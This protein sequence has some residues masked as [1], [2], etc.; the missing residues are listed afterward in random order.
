VERTIFLSEE[1][2]RHQSEEKIRLK[3]QKIYRQKAEDKKE[4]IRLEKLEKLNKLNQQLSK[5]LGKT[6]WAFDLMFQLI[7]SRYEIL[8]NKLLGSKDPNSKDLFF[9][10]FIEIYELTQDVN[11]VEQ[12]LNILNVDKKLEILTNRFDFYSTIPGL[13]ISKDICTNYINERLT[14][15]L[16]IDVILFDHL[17]DNID[18]VNDLKEVEANLYKGD[19][20][21]V[22][23]NIISYK[24]SLMLGMFNCVKSLNRALVISRYK[25]N[26]PSNTELYTIISNLRKQF[27][28]I[29]DMGNKLYPIYK[30][31]YSNTFGELLDFTDL[32]ILTQVMDKQDN[33]FSDYLEKKYIPIKDKISYLIENVNNDIRTKDISFSI[34][35]SN[36]SNFIKDIQWDSFYSKI[37]Q[38][39]TEASFHMLY[40]F[41]IYNLIDIL[42]PKL[43]IENYS[44]YIEIIQ[45][46]KD[47]KRERELLKEKQ[48]FLN[49]DFTLENAVELDRFN[50]NNIKTGYEFE[51]YLRNVFEKLG[52]EAQVTKASGDQGADLIIQK[53]G[54]I[55]VVQAKYYTGSVGNKAVQEITG[56]I[57]FYNA[58]KG[59]VVTNSYYTKSAIILAKAN[60]IVLIDGDG[61][62]NLKETIFKALNS[63]IYPIKSVENTVGA[64][65]E[66]IISKMTEEERL[67][68]LES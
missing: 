1:R 41:I 65:S 64:L 19:E 14:D 7:Y 61:L 60:N 49:G 43:L 67:D 21:G 48:R 59:M 37:N 5:E 22:K 23:W 34:L 20:T 3:D 58:H 18:W 40:S 4:K 63:N 36:F 51:H 6:Y 2:K 45:L 52:F 10:I 11:S 17:T 46:Y 32:L 38:P 26:L 39:G 57:N 25:N 33:P 27:P 12:F 15:K 42:P 50:F 35:I 31:F 55:T 16:T 66:D 30:E 24:V 13:D 54:E 68:Y 47:T 44:R 29:T 56:A 8:S 53:Q 28:N 62:S 9:S